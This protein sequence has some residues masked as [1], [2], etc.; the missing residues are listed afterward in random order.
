MAIMKHEHLTKPLVALSDD[1]E[2]AEKDLIANEDSYSRRNHI[3]ALFAMVEGSIYILKQTVLVAASSGTGPFSRAELA[4]LREETFDLK[5]NGHARTQ[6][7]FLKVAA[8][9]RFT[10]RCLEKAFGYSLEFN[11]TPTSW[12]DFTNAIK[13]RNR[14][15]HPKGLQDFEV[16]KEESELARR[17]GH[18]FTAFVGDW[19]GQF[20]A[21]ARA[22]YE[23]ESDP[24]KRDDYAM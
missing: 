3:R 12:D 6:K 9:L 23:D 18:W 1:L 11:A 2:R 20:V 10:K 7:K 19:F 16:S 24:G 13:I 21:T 5:D 22:V 14:V 15:T 17:V 4:V 8:N